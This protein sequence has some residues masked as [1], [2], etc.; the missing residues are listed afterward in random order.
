MGSLHMLRLTNKLTGFAFAFSFGVLTLTSAPNGLAQ[1]AS[2]LQGVIAANT[3]INKSGERSQAKIDK[4]YD[5]TEEITGQFRVES[6]R[7]ED[8]KIYNSQLQRQ[9]D[10][11]LKTIGQLTQ[12]I[13]E[14]TI[15]ERQISPLLL[16]MIASL[17]TFVSLDIPFLLDERQKRI[18]FLKDMMD[19]GDVTPAEQFRQVFESYQIENE[20]GSTIETYKGKLQLD[21]AEKE[22]NFLRIGRVALIYQTFDGKQ[23]GMWNSKTAAWEPV[24]TEYFTSIRQGFKVASQQAAPELIVLPIAAPEVM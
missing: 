3:Q 6:Q 13:D 5:Q 21:G 10:S 14:I 19:R 22:V 24:G 2:R 9:I 15:V 7:L 16:K 12:S 4:I 23:Q 17:E 18:A 11:Q 1:D 20:Y 8:L